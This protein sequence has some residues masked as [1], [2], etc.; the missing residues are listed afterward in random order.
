M[1]TETMLMRAKAQAEACDAASIDDL[2]D[3]RDVRIDP[4]LKGEER[5]RD[6]LRQVGNPY[7][8]RSGGVVVRVE[9]AGECTLADCI[10]RIVGTGPNWDSVPLDLGR[11]RP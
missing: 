3:I 6:F 10:G 5:I 2:K 7:L 1:K 8:F 4:E 9:F 11:P